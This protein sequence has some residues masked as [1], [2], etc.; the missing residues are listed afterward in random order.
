MSV[1]KTYEIIRKDI[2]QQIFSIDTVQ[3]AIKLNKYNILNLSR[4]LILETH[5][6]IIKLVE[7]GRDFLLSKNHTM[8][9]N[10]NYLDNMGLPLNDFVNVELHYVDNKNDTYPVHPFEIHNDDSGPNNFNCQTLIF[11]LENTLIDGNLYITGYNNELSTKIY[12]SMYNK[13]NDIK[14]IPDNFDKYISKYGP[15]IKFDTHLENTSSYI[16]C[17]T[18]DGGLYHFVGK[19]NSKGKRLAIVLQ[20]SLQDIFTR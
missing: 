15:I 2:F 20:Y 9:K 11:Y 8:I 16:K 4:S 1:F 14:F 6:L 19:I 13:L 5:P 12:E 18:F 10:I 3:E 7:Y 17:I